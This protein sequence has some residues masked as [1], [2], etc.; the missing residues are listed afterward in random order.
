MLDSEIILANGAAKG[1]QYHVNSVLSPS[2]AVVEQSFILI[3]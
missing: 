2:R 3:D 1:D